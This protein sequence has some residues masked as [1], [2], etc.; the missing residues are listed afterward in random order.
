MTK[1]LKGFQKGHKPFSIWLGRKHSEETKIKMSKNKLDLYK[2]KGSIIGFKTN[3]KINIGR[4]CRKET[5][6]KISIANKGKNKYPMSEEHKRK[7]SISNKGKCVSDEHKRKISIANK[8]RPSWNRGKKLKPLSE[9]H[10]KK[11]SIANKGHIVSEKTKEKLRT[12]QFNFIKTTHNITCPRIGYNEKQILDELE[13]IYNYKIVRQYKVLGYF[14]DGYIH[15]LNLA[16]EIDERP[17]IRFKDIE[18]ESNI[19]QELNCDFLRI[20]D[21]DQKEA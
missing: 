7:I 1:G 13:K 20:K 2:T 12:A 19:R 15:E 11:L 18:R 16:I 17:K 8:G 5:K 10:K 9:E 21:Y 14:L 6:N 4:E 3:H